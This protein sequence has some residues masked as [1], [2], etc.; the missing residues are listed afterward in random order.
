MKKL[1]FCEYS[2]WVHTH[3][4]SFSSQLKNNANRLKCLLNYKPFCPIVILHTSLLASFLS[5]E[6]TKV[7]WIWSLNIT[8]YNFYQKRFY[9]IGSNLKALLD[10]KSFFQSNLK[11]NKHFRFGQ[12]SRFVKP[13]KSSIKGLIKKER[14]QVAN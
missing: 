10:N 13:V 11:W 2:P 7:F 14:R 3:T 9:R 1:K 6:E 4:T 5:Y 12:K 8:P